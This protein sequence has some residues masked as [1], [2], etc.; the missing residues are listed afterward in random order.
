MRR[1][2]IALLFFALGIF[3][4]TSLAV[5]LSSE[6]SVKTSINQEQEKEFKTLF[7]FFSNTERDPNLTD[8]GK[9]YPVERVLS[10]FSN[11]GKSALG[12]FAYLTLADLLK[13]PTEIE[14]GLGFLTSINEGTKV[15]RLVIEGGIVHVDFNDKLNE[16]VAGSCRVQAIRS[17]IVETMIQFPEI[18]E[19]VIS[20]NGNSEEILQP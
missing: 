9:T 2:Q 4:I 13:G 5:Y 12:E 17:Q 20:I 3:T 16:G 11:N 7:V 6:E 10:R 1:Y 18:K 15:K 14:K 19:V 8:C